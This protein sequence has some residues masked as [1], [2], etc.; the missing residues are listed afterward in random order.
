[1]LG[2]LCII[3]NQR[4]F[5]LKSVDNAKDRI[6]HWGRNLHERHL[7]RSAAV[8]THSFPDSRSANNRPLRLN[9]LAGCRFF[10]SSA[11][12]EP[13]HYLAISKNRRRVIALPKPALPS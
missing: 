10:V 6:V 4:G 3:Y 5:L 13:I 1:M 12:A 11:I 9:L 8:S 7:P 2:S